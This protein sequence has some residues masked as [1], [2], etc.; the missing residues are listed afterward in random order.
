MTTPLPLTRI[1]I[2]GFRGLRQL[3][4]G[5]LGRVNVLVGGNNS[6]K[7]SVLEAISILAKPTQ[8]AAWIDMIRWRDPGGMDESRLHSLRWCFARLAVSSNPN[9]LQDG[10]CRFQV[11]GGFSLQRL[12]VAFQEIEGEPSADELKYA[13]RLRPQMEGKFLM[14]DWRGGEI[15]HKVLSAQQELFLPLMDNISTFRFWEGLPIRSRQANMPKN[16]QKPLELPCEVLAAYSYQGNIRQ[17]SAL[18][19]AIDST[20]EPSLVSLL[21]QF[22]PDVQDVDIRSTMGVRPAIYLKHARLGLAPLSIFGDA[23]RRAVLLASTLSSLPAG[24]VLL[25]DEAEAGIHVGAQQRFFA[26]ILQMAK[27]RQVQ[28]F[29]TTHSLEA[30]DALLMA[31]PEEAAGDEVVVFRLHHDQAQEPTSDQVQVK[32]FAG[33]LLHRLRFDRGLDVR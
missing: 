24:G 17:T 20:D 15:A 1:E 7:T 22:D 9:A 8:P 13:S 6:G 23:M 32:R 26:W 18:S 28:V 30:L 2:D 25:M 3:E 21:Q 27:Q 5:P 16:A 19:A 14:Q 11:E 12:D 10:A 29:M 4:L 31:M 33:D